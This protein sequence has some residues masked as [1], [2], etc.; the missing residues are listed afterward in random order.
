MEQYLLSR[1]IEMS[2]LLII[3]QFIR[4]MLRMGREV[5]SLNSS[6]PYI[7]NG[8]VF[9]FDLYTTLCLVICLYGC[10]TKALNCVG[11]KGSVKT[12]I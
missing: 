6:P 3:F 4:A 11:I 2:P 7:T 5:H 9:S 12:A 8:A 1:N 10:G